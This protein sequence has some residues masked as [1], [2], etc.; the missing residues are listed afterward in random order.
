MPRPKKTPVNPH[1]ETMPNY[2]GPGYNR[3]RFRLRNSQ[4]L[5]NQQ[6]IEH[7]QDTW[8]TAHQQRV[9]EWDTT[10]QPANITEEIEQELNNQPFE[11]E[12][13]REPDQ[14]QPENM[15][16]NMHEHSSYPENLP[17][18]SEFIQSCQVTPSIVELSNVPANTRHKRSKENKQNKTKDSVLE[19]TDDT[20]S[21]EHEITSSEILSYDE[22]SKSSS[23]SSN[24]SE[25]LKRKRKSKKH[26]KKAIR[27][28]GKLLDL[29]KADNFVTPYVMQKLR[30]HQYVK[31]YIFTDIRLSRAKTTS[32]APDIDKTVEFVIAKNKAQLVASSQD[33]TVKSGPEDCDLTIDQLRQAAPR[34]LRAIKNAGWGKPVVKM[35]SDFFKSFF[36]HSETLLQPINNKFTMAYVLQ[37]LRHKWHRALEDTNRATKLKLNASHIDSFRQMLLQTRFLEQEKKFR[38]SLHMSD[39][40]NNVRNKVR[41]ILTV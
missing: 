40:T 41:I 24:T 20:E 18:L 28:G 25:H 27:L 23:D 15:E 29:D 33:P 30:K 8:N 4:N 26:K 34:F 7:L 1:T 35:Y 14:I 17:P 13:E 3:L 5:T 22:S 36:S 39:V 16:Q 10:H 38:V 11:Q 31:L 2:A 9:N 37:D 32:L 21:T 12:P 19:D 6:V